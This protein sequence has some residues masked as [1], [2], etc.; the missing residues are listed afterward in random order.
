LGQK[1]SRFIHFT[2]FFL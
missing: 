1:L 2:A